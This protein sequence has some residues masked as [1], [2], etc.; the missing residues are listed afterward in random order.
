M[1]ETPLTPQDTLVGWRDKRNANGAEGFAEVRAYVDTDYNIPRATTTAKDAAEMPKRWVR[2][3]ADDGEDRVELTPAFV[4][5][6][7]DE[8]LEGLQ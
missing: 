3:P 2:G 8:I 7:M 1:N 5:A 4:T 6:N